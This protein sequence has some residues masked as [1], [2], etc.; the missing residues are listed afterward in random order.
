MHDRQFGPRPDVVAMHRD[1]DHPNVDVDLV[2]LANKFSDSPRDLTAPQWNSSQDN[3]SQIGIT[4]N[5]FVRDPP[6]GA[7]NGFRVHDRDVARR[8]LSF[9]FF[10]H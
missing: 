10:A 6:Q 8:S 3:R 7:A 1:I 2:Y 9:L 4:L 5:N